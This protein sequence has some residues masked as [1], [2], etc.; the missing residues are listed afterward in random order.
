MTMNFSSDLN[1]ASYGSSTH[2]TLR[3]I[4]MKKILLLLADGFEEYGFYK[5]AYADGFTK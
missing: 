3:K 1:L 5:D 2:A 4:F